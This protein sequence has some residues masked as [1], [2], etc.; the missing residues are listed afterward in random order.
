MKE[1]RSEKV[2]FWRAGVFAEEVWKQISEFDFFNDQYVAVVD[3]NSILWDKEFHSLK[4][5]SPLKL[6]ELT[7]DIFVITSNIY[8]IEIKNQ[9][10]YDLNVSEYKIYSFEEYKRKSFAKWRYDNRYYANDETYNKSFDLKKVIVY[11]AITGQYD[12]LKEPLYKDD[13]L[14]YVCFTNNHKLKSN[15]WNIEYIC[16]TSLDDMQL[17]KKIKL[18]PFKFFKEYE[19]SIWVDGKFEIKDDMKQYIEKYGKDKPI[20]CFP[21][22]SRNC[23]YDEAMACLYLNKVKKEQIIKQISNYYQMNYPFDNGLY[24]MGCIVRRHNDIFLQKLMQDWY[25]EI[26][27]YSYRDQISF[28]VVCWKNNFLPDICDLDINQNRWIKIYSH[29]M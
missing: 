8:E 17:A 3:N 24:E 9:L 23:I 7:V 22:Y 26:K 5:I 15:F 11:T 29:N 14:T 4:I 28:P 13:K 6:K 12:N 1:I 16:D 27:H 19:T 10:K 18:Q 20:L 21:H 2:V 25:F